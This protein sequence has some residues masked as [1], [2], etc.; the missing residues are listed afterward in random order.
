M[1]LSCPLLRRGESGIN[2][3]SIYGNSKPRNTFMARVKYFRERRTNQEMTL[4]IR[5]L[6][7]CHLKMCKYGCRYL[8]PMVAAD[9]SQSFFCHIGHMLTGED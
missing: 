4:Q 7:D 5:M 6:K 3:E 2:R 1:I 9:K 8:R